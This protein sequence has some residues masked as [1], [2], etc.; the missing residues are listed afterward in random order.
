LVVDTGGA[1]AML[2]PVTGDQLWRT[3][4]GADSDECFL[5]YR[6]SPHPLFARGTIVGDRLL[7]PAL[8]GDIVILDAGTGAVLGRFATEVPALAPLVVHDDTAVALHRDGRL[9][10]YPLAAFWGALS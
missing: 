4:V 8:D 1:V 3:E 2:D 7:I 6:R 5:A 10:A 9:V